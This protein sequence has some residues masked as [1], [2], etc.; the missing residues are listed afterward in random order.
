MNTDHI[1]GLM[2]EHRLTVRGTARLLGLSDQGFYNKLNGP[3]DFTA[4]EVKKLS[5][6]LKVSIS[7]LFEDQKD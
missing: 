1:R 3:S 2:R 6:I 4:S 7:E 5:E